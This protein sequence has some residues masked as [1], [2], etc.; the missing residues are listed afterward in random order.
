MKQT[1]DA[2]IE[3]ARSYSPARWF[4]TGKPHSIPT[5][6][7]LAFH[8]NFEKIRLSPE[9][10]NALQPLLTSRDALSLIIF[11]VRMAIFAVRRHDKNLI[12]K[13]IWAI[14][15]D[16]N[17]ADWRDALVALAII[18]DCAKRLSM[19]FGTL[20]GKWLYL[21]PPKRLRTIEEG[22]LARSNAMRTVQVMGY[23]ASISSDG[24]LEY[25]KK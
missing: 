11:A 10:V 18:E 21:A 8:E 24:M 7:E 15:L 6:A 25:I 5:D 13:A 22:Y 23:T 19:D 2:V 12:E 14:C 1:L 17:I 3:L 4:P 20:I 16:N 9:V